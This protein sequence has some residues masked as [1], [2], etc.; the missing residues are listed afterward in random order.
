MVS[1][2]QLKRNPPIAVFFL[3]LLCLFS[4][5]AKLVSSHRSVLPSRGTH[6]F[7]MLPQCRLFTRYSVSCMLLFAHVNSSCSFMLRLWCLRVA[8]TLN[9]PPRLAAKDSISS[10]ILALSLQ[11]TPT[12]STINTLHD[13]ESLLLGDQAFLSLSTS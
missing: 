5:Y 3:L 9:L 4:V 12:V 7:S 8:T 11:P 10:G 1:T 13:T 6:S 2:A